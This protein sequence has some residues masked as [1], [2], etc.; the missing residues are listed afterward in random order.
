MASVE[1][2]LADEVVG[3]QHGLVVVV[4]H[5]KRNSAVVLRSPP[6][7]SPTQGVLGRVLQRR[8]QHDVASR[9]RKQGMLGNVGG[10]V[11][12]AVVVCQDLCSQRDN[13]KSLCSWDLPVTCF[14]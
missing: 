3:V 9:K 11:L 14:S 12:R 4:L 13:R 1:E 6:G 2:L 8:G 7:D 5:A 10:H